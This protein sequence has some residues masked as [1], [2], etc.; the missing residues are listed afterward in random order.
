MS[1]FCVFNFLFPL[2][3]D[4]F[5][6]FYIWLWFFTLS[7][8]LYVV[9]VA[10]TENVTTSTGKRP[11][12]ACVVLT[13]QTKAFLMANDSEGGHESAALSSRQAARLGEML[14]SE[15]ETRTVE[16]FVAR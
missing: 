1:K 14:P 4:V 13:N 6:R 16:P 2:F 8:V 9:G 15:L 10:R 12:R 7:I 5:P 3:L 11:C